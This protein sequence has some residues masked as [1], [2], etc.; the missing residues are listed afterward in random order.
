MDYTD[1]PSAI[2]MGG[3]DNTAPNEHD[4]ASL[5]EIYIHLDEV[6]VVAIPEARNATTVYRRQIFWL[7]FPPTVFPGGGV[8]FRRMA[9]RRFTR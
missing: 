1:D 5:E 4:Y 3:T 7:A 2:G 8:S 9:H 6:V